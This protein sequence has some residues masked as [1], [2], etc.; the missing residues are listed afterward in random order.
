MHR[1][2]TAREFVR[3]RA[4]ELRE[5]GETVASI[6]HYLNVSAPSVTRWT[7]L[8]KAGKPLNPPPTTGRPPRLD[9]ND[10]S[11]LARLLERGATDHGWPN[12]LWTTKR[13]RDLIEREFGV[14]FSRSHAWTILR[15]YLG[16][17]SQQPATRHRDRD[18][19]KIAKWP[20]TKF[21]TILREAAKHNAYIA[22]I[23]EAGFMLMPTLR[24]T[25]APCGKRPIVKTAEPHGRISTACALTVSPKTQRANIYFQML[26]DDANYN[27]GSTA[28]FVRL[29]SEKI[30]APIIIIWDCIPIHLAKPVRAVTQKRGSISLRMLPKYAP[31]L[32]PADKV[33]AYVKYARLAN[34]APPTLADLRAIVH[35]ELVSLKSRTKLLH[36]FIRRAGLDMKLLRT[37]SKAA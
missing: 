17:T 4:V 3:R 12:D 19:E 10:L 33:W 34:F 25:F 35:S 9:R 28:N 1:S 27:G 23:D 6:C 18:E 5:Q 20:T 8:A 13:V 37:Q 30:D 15:T 16:W 11:E 22:F 36:S 24:R 26:A 29:L 32:N 2:E 21:R 31:E 7:R 14:S